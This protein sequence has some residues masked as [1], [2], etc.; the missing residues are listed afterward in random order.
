MATYRHATSGSGI[1]CRRLIVTDALTSSDD[2]TFEIQQPANSIVDAVFVRVL[3]DLEIASGNIGVKVGTQAGGDQVVAADTDNLLAS[4]T[5]IPAGTVY[6]LSVDAGVKF[7]AIANGSPSA[8]VTT[9]VR[10]LH[11]TLSSSTDVASG[12]NGRI[13]FS[14]A[15]RIFE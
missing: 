3:D 9:E 11:F 12:G 8:S 15:Y 6:S 1:H 14:V 4:G 10:D 2:T 7:Q 5:D 13:E